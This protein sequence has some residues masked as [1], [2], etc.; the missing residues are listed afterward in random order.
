LA[1]GIIEAETRRRSLLYARQ[2]EA[3]GISVLSVYVDGLILDT[4]RLPFLPEGWEVEAYLTDLVFQHP[5]SWTSRTISKQPGIPGRSTQG[6]QARRM[7]AAARGIPPEV[8]E[9][10]A[11]RA[12]ERNRK[13]GEAILRNARWR[14]KQE[15]A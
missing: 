10:H 6:E 1:R 7:A 14:L 15:A 2:L 13:A 9:A 12:A 4:D 3:K 11:A 5:N 8:V